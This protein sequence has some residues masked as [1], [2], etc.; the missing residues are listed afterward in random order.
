MEET[1]TQVGTGAA[2]T[3]GKTNNPE[4]QTN[5]LNTSGQQKADEIAS[6]FDELMDN[7][8]VHVPDGRYNALIKTHLEQACFY[9]KKGLS[10]NPT[11]QE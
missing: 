3:T 10:A 8:K 2:R 4:F 6:W 11:N 9:A 1:M 7:L 5:R